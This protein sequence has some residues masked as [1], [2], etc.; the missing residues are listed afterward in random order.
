MDV[1]MYLIGLFLIGLVAFLIVRR[2]KA[3]RA[4]KVAD[5]KAAHPSTL[6]ARD[7]QF[8]AKKPTV[9]PFD[10]VTAHLAVDKLNRKVEDRLGGQHSIPNDN[11][12]AD[13]RAFVEEEEAA[14]R[15]AN[16]RRERELREAESRVKRQQEE[17]ARQNQQG[18]YDAKT[19][20]VFW[21]G[22][23]PGAMDTP[24]HRDEDSTSNVEQSSSNTSGSSEEYTGIPAY[25]G[26]DYSS[27]SS[28]SSSSYSSSS[29]SSSSSGGGS[30]D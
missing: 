6:A 24:S 8:V 15:R 26:S 12:A 20:S 25:G 19:N 11:R 30:S 7:T 4:K 29:D 16:I 13:A 14:I 3:A 17:E 21:P 10:P 18:I 22:V 28:D 1:I 9:V 23:F 2:V 5:A 27:S